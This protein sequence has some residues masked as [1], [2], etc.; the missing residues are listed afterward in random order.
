MKN[1]DNITQS[2]EAFLKFWAEEIEKQQSIKRQVEEGERLYNQW[3]EN[4]TR[5]IKESEK[6]FLIIMKDIVSWIKGSK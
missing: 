3:V 1:N 4:N 6:K 2:E 5:Q